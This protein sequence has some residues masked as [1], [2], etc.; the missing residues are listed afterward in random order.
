MDAEIA[1][2]G[3]VNIELFE[4][5]HTPMAI[6]AKLQKVEEDRYQVVFSEPLPRSQ[7]RLK[8][9][10]QNAKVYAIEGDLDV[11]RIEADNTLLRS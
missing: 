6:T 4:N 9:S 10:F 2:D 1:E 11:S 7:T 5:N 3:F 8:I